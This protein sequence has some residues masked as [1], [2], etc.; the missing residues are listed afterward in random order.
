MF[1]ITFLAGALCCFVLPTHS[2]AESSKYMGTSSCSSSNC[3]GAAAPRK[4]TNIL[5]N[6]YV[7]WQRHDKHSKAWEVLNGNEAQVMAKHLGM[8]NP[9]NEALCLDCHA[10]TAD[11]SSVFGKEFQIEDGVTCETCHGAAGG[12]LKSH[13]ER[14]ATHQR[15]LDSGMRNLVSLEERAKL[16]SACHIGNL[17][18]DVSHRL[19]GAGHPRLSFELDT[20]GVIEPWHWE[21]DRDYLARK[22]DYSAVKAWLFG[23]V[24]IGEQH[25]E[26]IGSA[27]HMRGALF[28]EFSRFYCFSCHHSLDQKQYL[29]SDYS[30]NPG[31]PQLN[32]SSLFIVRGVAPVLNPKLAPKLSELMQQLQTDLKQGDALGK[33]LR[34]LKAVLQEIKGAATN[35]AENKTT[36]DELLVALVQAV[37][38]EKQLYYEQAEQ[39]AMGISAIVSA[40]WS[41]KNPIQREV[42]LMFG[43]LSKP[44]HFS[45]IEFRQVAQR[46]KQKLD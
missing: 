17:R 27:D 28:P 16:C 14:G 38:L 8:K 2:L 43:V 40:R 26:F 25:L 46:L 42:D 19:Y 37:T 20:F 5:Q 41:G 4:S 29:S 15:N 1:R 36:Y 32:L 7:T 18:Q 21:I 6:E 13:V 10:T 33:K 44:E 31:L 23:Q 11:S 9:A 34:E 35:L 45:A 22:Q 30:G 24:V 39:I 3:H 12:W